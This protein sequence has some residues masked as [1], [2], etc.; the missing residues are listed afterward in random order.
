MT[1]PL[2][3]LTAGGW[4]SVSTTDLARALRGSVPA[5]ACVVLGD[6]TFE[7]LA[8]QDVDR[9]SLA[10]LF[11][12]D[13]A[14]VG[15]VG[16]ISKGA[17]TL[18][19]FLRVLA[20]GARA[21][22]RPRHVAFI[23]NLRSFG[24]VWMGT[25]A[26]QFNAEAAWLAAIAEGAGTAS[27]PAEEVLD[28]EA[29]FR[30]TPLAIN[31]VRA[32]TIGALQTFLA[33]KSDTTEP[34][35]LR[36]VFYAYHGFTI[37][38]DHP[39]LESLRA[40]V[41]LALSLGAQVHAYLAPVNLEAAVLYAGDDM[42]GRVAA[43]VAAVRQALGDRLLRNDVRLLDLTS[44]FPASTFLRPTHPTEHL[45]EEGRRILSRQ[46]ARSILEAHQPRE[47][48]VTRD[49][50][51]QSEVL[52]FYQANRVSPVGQSIEDL[53]AH[54]R[55]RR[56][57]Y[58][59]LGLSPL[60]VRG[61]RVV[62][63]GPGSGHN[64]L[65]TAS[66]RP[67][68]YV[69]VD[70]NRTGID[71]TRALMSRHGLFDG[72]ISQVEALFLDYPARPEFDLVLCEGV[73]NIQSDPAALVRHIAAC[74]APG[75]ILMLTCV[76]AVSFLPEIGR[77]LLARLI[78][79]PELPLDQRLDLVRPYFLPHVA[80]LPGMS[81]LPDHWIIDV[82]LVPRLGRFW[83][84]DEAVRLL[85]GDFDILATSPRF[86][87]DWRWYKTV[88]G[89]FNAHALAEF[90][91]WRHCLID[92]RDTPAPAAAQT[93]QALA[94]GCEATCAA[95]EVAIAAATPDLAPILAELAALRPLVQTAAPKT[96]PALDDLAEVL[97][98]W[99]PGEQ[100]RPTTAF[101]PW[102]GR[103]QQYLTLVNR[104]GPA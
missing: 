81:R 76:D 58:H 31:G 56:S 93:V 70:G 50:S 69:L 12:G 75:G 11:L 61:R 49:P 35:R 99:R 73:T 32:P 54:F 77:R 43:N 80:A 22:W 78:A 87:A 33:D 100:P 23:I 25:P 46:L 82:L 92:C 5:P 45:N 6:S 89:S 102:F 3:A 34:Q 37:P 66:L 21:G 1:D 15:P 9:R 16:V 17:Y 52:A 104:G 97:A 14:D 20:A 44:A 101:T 85:D 13:L 83:G 4:H 19:L 67:A 84:L 88:D 40:I 71:E 98:A 86:S 8:H 65:Y 68:S 79:P 30:A 59:L 24:P 96:L 91:R 28:D 90:D 95:M 38:P 53:D 62:E 39:R 94:Q 18:P 55:R 64:C 41:D 60:T 10:E 27:P 57:L 51:A 47:T 2:G 42:R 7:R 74:V 48:V 29:P 103:G 36:E 72:T 26:W 63:F